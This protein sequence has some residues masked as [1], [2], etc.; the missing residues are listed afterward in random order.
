MSKYIE[1]KLS[2]EEL[3]ALLEKVFKPEHKALMSECLI[4][5]I[6]DK[7]LATLA[8]CAMGVEPIMK[9]SVGDK[10]ICR[11]WGLNSSWKLDEQKMLN[12]NMLNGKDSTAT[13]TGEIKAVDKF[14]IQ[15]YAIAY[16][17]LGSDSEEV[18]SDESKV[19]EEY[20]GD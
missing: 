1:M 5:I 18:Q 9:Y 15:Q 14:Q 12:A 17:Y 2:E 11:T 8:K 3:F 7:D 13:L 20:P 19:A 16:E 10:V 6:P 4:G